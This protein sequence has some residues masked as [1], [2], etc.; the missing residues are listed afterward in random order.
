M[1]QIKKT[2]K[3][4]KIGMI[5]LGCDK[6]RVDS[7][8]ILYK[9]RSFGY[10][11]TSNPTDAD[12]IIINTCAFI[13]SAKKESIDLILDV[14]EIKKRKQIKIIVI[15]CLAERYASKIQT[16][17][18]EVDVFAG[19]GTYDDIVS[20]IETGKGI[21]MSDNK[22]PVLQNQRLI[23]TPQHYAYLK[24]ADGCDNFC[25]YCAIP[26]I[27][28]RYRSYKEEDLLEEARILVD[29]GVEEIIIV[30]QDTVRY[31]LDLYGEPRLINL[32][33]S[34]SKL[35]L[36]KIRLMYAYPELVTSALIEYIS[37]EPKMAKYIDIPFQHVNDNLLKKMNRHTNCSQI[38]GIIEN[39][40]GNYPEISLRSSFIVGFPGEDEQM[41]L[42][43][44]N[45]IAKG[46][47]DY[48]GFFAYSREEGTVAYKMKD[49]I[50]KKIINSR[51]KE[52]SV[53]QSN[54]ICNNHKK[55]FKKTMKVT[56]EG[57]DFDK[58]IFWGRNEYNAPEIDTKVFF[59]SNNL[60]EIGQVYNV[61]I[62]ET[63]FHL[64]GRI[65]P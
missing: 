26:F 42:D 6:N 47:V 59:T 28:G 58:N 33:E 62:L 25:S 50:P 8:K 44:K 15:G 11:F 3:M 5:S 43:L 38:M 51:L 17:L 20:M 52:L 19:L 56:Y 63:G 53:L 22:E 55:Y 36:Y 40:K 16:Q 27:R 9:L 65:E 54:N 31:G 49:Q 61:K 41:Y 46:I 48:A 64:V 37:E 35:P 18:P 14:A 30:A 29:N 7:E 2:D 24:I 23:T 39:I 4:K 13:E 32:L 60:V 21:Y 12:I 57:I 45:F 34:I 10:E 1:G